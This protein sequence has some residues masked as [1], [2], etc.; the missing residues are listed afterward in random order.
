VVACNVLG[1]TLHTIGYGM[2]FDTTHNTYVAPCREW[3][4]EDVTC[5]DMCPKPTPPPTHM[6]WSKLGKWCHHMWRFE[7]LAKKTHL[8]RVWVG[9]T[10]TPTPIVDCWAN[11]CYCSHCLA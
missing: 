9:L 3:C 4:I 6:G 10:Y 8:A 5:E 11:L 7:V 2:A 1:W